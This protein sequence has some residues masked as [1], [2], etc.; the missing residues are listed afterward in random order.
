MLVWIHAV[1]YFT[2]VYFVWKHSL[3]INQVFIYKSSIHVCIKLL[4]GCKAINMWHDIGSNQ[5][6]GIFLVGIFWDTKALLGTRSHQECGCPTPVRSNLLFCGLGILLIN[7]AY[8]PYS[9]HDFSYHFLYHFSK[10]I[11]LG[12]GYHQECFLFL[13]HSIYKYCRICNMYFTPEVIK[14][15]TVKEKGEHE[16]TTLR[17]LRRKFH[18]ILLIVRRDLNVFYYR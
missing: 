18:W 4:M 3:W 15:K 13:Y 9:W 6:L 17:S 7:G 2:F 5:T 16:L 8:V 12:T 1:L 14:P 11:I 10:R